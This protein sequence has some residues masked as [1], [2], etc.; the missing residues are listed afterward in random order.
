MRDLL[1]SALTSLRYEPSEK[2]LR[3]YLDG[4][5][6]ADTI[7]GLAGVGAAALGPDLRGAAGRLRGAAGIG[8]AGRRTCRLARAG[9]DESLYGAYLYRRD[10]RR[11]CRC[12]AMPVGG[13]PARRSGPGRLISP[14]TS[15]RSNGA[16]KTSR[17]SR[18]RTTRSNASTSS[19]A[20]DM[21][22][23]S[24]T[25]GCWPSRRG[26]CCCSRPRC[27]SGSTF[28][29]ADVAVDLESTDTVSDCAYKGR[30]SYFRR[31]MVPP[32]SRGPTAIRF[33]RPSPSGITSRSSTSGSTSSSM[34]S[35]QR[36]VTPFSD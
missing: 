18:T 14:S 19:P 12:A 2:R 5:P 8:G 16:R 29:P 7:N 9:P 26:R 22:A 28:P 11:H 4:E 32:T 21:S 17:S 15:A 20:P 24:R 33:A 27:R 1:D 31:R 13:V 30:A 10:V 23:S 36:P 35:P 3:T 25:A 6:V 34:A